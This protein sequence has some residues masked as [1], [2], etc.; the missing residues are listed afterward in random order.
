MKVNKTGRQYF[1]KNEMLDNS[2]LEAILDT[3]VSWIANCDSKAAA[4]IGWVSVIISILGVTG[5][6]SSAIDLMLLLMSLNAVIVVF[7]MLFMLMFLV[8]FVNGFLLLV[9]V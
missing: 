6:L 8:V 1:I 5:V 3:V 7:Y 4:L 9:I 2:N